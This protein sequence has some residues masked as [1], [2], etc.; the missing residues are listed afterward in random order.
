MNKPLAD[1]MRPTS[2]EEMV[3][4]RHLFDSDK[5]F[6]K[7]LQ[8][9]HVPNMIFYGPPGVG[10]TCTANIIA[11]MSNK[12]IYKLNGTTAKTEDLKLVF[13]DINLLNNSNGILLYL[14]EIQYFNK[15]QQQTLLE[16]IENGSVTLIASTTE[17]PLFYIYPALLSRCNVFEFKLLQKE[18]IVQGIKNVLTKL[19][20][21]LSNEVIDILST[22]A[23]GD[24]RKALNNLEFLLNTNETNSITV[25]NV[26]D[27]VNKSYYNYDAHG[28]EHYNTLS[29]F[30]K[31]LRGSDPD[32]AI[33][34]LARLLNGNDIISVIRR[35]MCVASEDVG[36]AHP[37]ALEVTKAGCDMALYLGMPEASLPLS[38]V[39]IYLATCPKSNSSMMAYS[40]AKDLLQKGLGIDIPRHLKNTH[41]DGV[42]QLK[43]GQYYKYPHDYKNHYVKQRY[44]PH[45]LEDVKF[46]DAQNNRYENS[47][48][49]Y[50]NKIKGEK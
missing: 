47:I 15:K 45:D 32:A 24:L 12:Q 3:G 18:D 40:R 10:K 36:L 42:D 29:A 9:K 49:D 31:S 28:D 25:E 19:N 30:H 39:T 43:K 35:L 14:D 8:S 16:Y 22:S 5:I 27:L 26:L 2:F 34:Y 44:L 11:K 6:Y 13:E 37:G 23:S 48:V 7:S 33:F 50:W 46:Y 4:Q 20:K 41:F 21:E 38:E 1:L 17:N